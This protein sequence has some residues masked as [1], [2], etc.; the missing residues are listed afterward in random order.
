MSN[1]LLA[2]ECSVE[3]MALMSSQSSNQTALL[4]C[5]ASFTGMLTATALCRKWQLSQ[6]FLS[7]CNVHSGFNHLQKELHCLVLE[8]NP[9]S[10][11]ATLKVTEG[12][13]ILRYPSLYPAH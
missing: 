13:W 9:K 11:I 3:A 8:H 12:P 4:V 10:Q 6:T 1:L 2:G 7:N 5:L